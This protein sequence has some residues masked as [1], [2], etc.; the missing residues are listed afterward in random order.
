MNWSG[1]WD[2]Q[3]N[4]GTWAPITIIELDMEVIVCDEHNRVVNS[5]WDKDTWIR[6]LEECIVLNR[7]SRRTLIHKDLKRHSL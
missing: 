5:R 1:E 3:L 4:D 6:V 2:F 7:L